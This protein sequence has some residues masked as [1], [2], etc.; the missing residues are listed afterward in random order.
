MIVELTNFTVWGKPWFEDGWDGLRSFCAQHGLS[1]IELLGSGAK[2]DAAPPA[3]LIGGL[4]LRSLGQWLPLAGLDVPEFGCGASRY[5]A[6]QGYEDL[7]QLRANELHHAAQFE[8]GYVV[9]HAC[10]A[11]YPQM[12]GGPLILDADT[13]L[14]RLAKLVRDVFAVYEPPFPVCFENGFGVGLNY[15]RP[16]QVREFMDALNELPVG[17]VIDTGH[18]LNGHRE[19]T[20]EEAACEALSGI[21]TGLD[22]AGVRAQV[23]HLHWTPPELVPPGAWDQARALVLD[24]PHT[25]ET[26]QEVSD[27]FA[28]CDQHQPLT[29]SPV[30]SMVQTFDPRIVVHELGAMSL[31]DHDA[32]LSLQTRALRGE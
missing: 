9:W 8:P 29:A 20:T 26:V 30:R 2:P 7:V 14:E 24:G 1:G 3:D 16:R 11:P 27:F 19:F 32:W 25:E 4:H 18:F 15:E 22:A 12:F 23:M 31:H 13:F 28:R 6:A 21:A 10:Y 17:L 5:A